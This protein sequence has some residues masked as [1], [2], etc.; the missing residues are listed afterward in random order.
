MISNAISR[1]ERYLDDFCSGL[2]W[3]L[4]LALGAACVAIL[5]V[6]VPFL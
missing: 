3:G 5:T 1:R 2:C 4:G 6:V